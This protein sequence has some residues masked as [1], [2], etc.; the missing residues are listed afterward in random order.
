MRDILCS[1]NKNKIQ[2]GLFVL[3]VTGSPG[4]PGGARFQNRSA[5][6]PGSLTLYV[7]QRVP[8]VG[9]E[10]VGLPRPERG[11]I[12]IVAQAEWHS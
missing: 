10:A 5:L 12:R 9:S 1:F 3:W 8:G 11:W 7:L 2:R 4:P 6:R